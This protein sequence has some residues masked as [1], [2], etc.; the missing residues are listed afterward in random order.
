MVRSHSPHPNDR[1]DNRATFK[2]DCRKLAI[3][4]TVQQAHYL[5][6]AC[7]PVTQRQCHLT[8]RNQ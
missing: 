6:L 8:L 4:K 2:I 7:V 1:I 3:A 5:K